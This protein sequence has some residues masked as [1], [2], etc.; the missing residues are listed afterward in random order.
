M[1]LWDCKGSSLT[2]CAFTTTSRSCG[3]ISSQVDCLTSNLTY[4]C[5]SQGDDCG[6]HIEEKLLFLANEKVLLFVDNREGY[7]VAS[8]G[9]LHHIYFLPT[10]IHC[11]TI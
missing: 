10:F 1:W 5:K 6:P 4:K 11:I 2:F 3:R 9:I 7:G 8:N